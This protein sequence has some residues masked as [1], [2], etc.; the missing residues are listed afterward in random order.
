MRTI[1]TIEELAALPVGSVVLAHWPD[2]RQPDH[3]VVRVSEGGAG[4]RGWTLA[5]PRHWKEMPEWG[6]ELTI[7]FVPGETAEVTPESVMGLDWFTF[8]DPYV[9]PEAPF[10]RRDDVLLLLQANRT[11]PEV[12]ISTETPSEVVEQANAPG[13]G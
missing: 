7:V 10:V 13:A 9:D 11:A 8:D 3:R 6:A 1:T 4:V 12:G 5:G 2:G